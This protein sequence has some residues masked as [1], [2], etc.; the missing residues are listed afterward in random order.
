[1]SLWH[2]CMLRGRGV[3]GCCA[4]TLVAAVHDV[5]CMRRTL[6]SDVMC[7]R[8][9]LLSDVMCMRRTLLSQEQACCQHAVVAVQVC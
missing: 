6:L 1:V 2:P 4:D 9:T 5:M 8:R 7:M 3:N